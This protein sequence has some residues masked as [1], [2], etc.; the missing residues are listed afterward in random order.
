[1]LYN[2]EIQTK[3]PL[4]I[5]SKD[6]ILNINDFILFKGFMYK[7]NENK[8]L[9]SLVDKN[10]QDKF[11]GIVSKTVSSF[12]ISKFLKDNSLYNKEFIKGVSDYRSKW[13]IN[14]DKTSFR[15]F[16][17][18]ARGK[19]YIPGSSIKGALRTA[20]S[21]YMLKRIKKIDKNIFDDIFL[22]EIKKCLEIRNYYL[23]DD[24]II[25]KLLKNYNLKHKA[26]PK[27]ESSNKDILRSIKIS[28]SEPLNSTLNI[29]EVAVLN[30]TNNGFKEKTNLRMELLPQ[31]VNIKFRLKIDE[32][33]L[34]DFNKKVSIDRIENIMKAGKVFSDDII[35]AENKFYNYKKIR[36]QDLIKTLKNE[37]KKISL[38]QLKKLKST[39]SHKS[40]INIESLIDFYEREKA[41]NLRLGSGS[42]I[43]GVTFIMLLPNN[44]KMKLRNKLDKYRK[45]NLFPKT[46]KIVKE[47][48]K[49]VS[50]LGWGKLNNI[51]KRS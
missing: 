8:L 29:K 37:G 6:Q 36:N 25:C 46:H 32:D 35:K 10:L 5:G 14:R 40:K 38:A 41:M 39:N 15:P 3:S 26:S 50:P 28:D 9:K 2:M 22:N 21:Y 18:N 20:N 43:L 12:R 49:L 45:I 47:K 24:K 19:P 51:E 27:I 4:F 31:G 7:I 44:L 13:E 16:I 34:K 23:Q 1:M 42:G 48:G 30:L 17:K 33:I 11:Y